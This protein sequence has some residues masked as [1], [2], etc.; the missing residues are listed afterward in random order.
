MG[1]FSGSR[2]LMGCMTYA[3]IAMSFNGLYS[4]GYV[5]ILD[6][7]GVNMTQMG[8]Y[9]MTISITGIV[10]CV[11]LTSIKKKLSLKT[12]LYII[13]ALSYVVAISAKLLGASRITLMLFL[14]VGGA[15]LILGGHVMM[16]EIVSNW[17][18]M[19][20]ANK[21]S[22]VF[23][24]AMFGQAA[25][26]FIGG[27]FYS[28][29]GLLDSWFILYLINGTLLLGVTHFLIISSKP[30][31]VGQKAFGS[32]SKASETE[33]EIP[34]QRVSRKRSLYQNPVFW[35]CLIGDMGLSGGVNYITTYAT[36]F[37]EKGGLSLGVSSLILGCATLSAAVCSFF[38]GHILERFKVKG[39]IIILLG[40]VI[41]ANLM[42][43]AYGNYPM[44]G[45]ILLMILFYGLGYSGAHCINIVSRIIFE[46]EDAADANSKISGI[47]MIGG[48]IFLPVSGYMAEHVGF[49]AMYI[50]IALTAAISLVSY[51]S[52]LK[53]V[54]WKSGCQTTE[55][56]CL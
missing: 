5:K 35:L 17:Y 40:S 50:L 1:K 25:F 39:Y 20:R 37:F 10:C 51:L 2:V 43:I 7:F 23:G 12:I 22:L 38:N 31:E 52:A 56:D 45:M 16:S 48:L 44:N 53:M 8:V 4:S 34:F 18:E 3:F 36:S 11:S 14:L 27:Q 47:A 33:V 42:M 24:F 46:P 26:Q 19:G 13:A 28:H 32:S 15:T 41:L 30:E 55:A 29:L 6:V 21:I 49:S 9:S 54:E